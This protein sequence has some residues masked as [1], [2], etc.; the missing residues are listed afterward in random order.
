MRTIGYWVTTVLSAAA[1][2]VPGILNLLH[3]A[4]IMQDMTHLGFPAYLPTILGVWKIL[5]ALVI[6]LPGFPRLKEW[7]YAGMVFDLTGAAISRGISGDAA[8]T[9]IVPLLI[10]G[11]VLASWALRPT[12]RMLPSVEA[13]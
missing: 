10:A 6:V 4:H 5:G 13:L 9:V 7:A 2:M 12:G 3:S 1:F 8:V 11:V